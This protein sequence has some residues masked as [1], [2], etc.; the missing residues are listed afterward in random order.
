VATVAAEPETR[1]VKIP[2]AFDFL[3]EPH[4]YKVA[5]GGRGSGKS[6]SFAQLLLIEAIKRRIR[7]L[8]TR[9]IQKSI[10]DSVHQVLR[11]QIDR[12]GMESHFVVQETTIKSSTGSEFIFKGLQANTQ[13]IKSTERIN[14]CW[15]EEAESVTKDSWD[16][17]LPTILR[18]SDSELWV[19]FNTRHEDDDTY[20]RFVLNPPPGCVSRKV[21][22]SDNPWCPQ[23]LIEQ[24]EHMYAIDPD[25]A[26]HVWGGE[27]RNLSDAQ[28]LRGRYCVEAFEPQED[29]GGPYYGA[30][31][32]FAVDPTTLVRCWVHER[33]LYIE[34]EAY[35][36]GVDLDDTP[37]LF[38]SVP[39][40]RQHVIRADSARPETINHMVNHGFPRMAPAQKGPGSV[41]DGVEHLRS[42]KS[43]VIHPR[44]K[45][46]AQEA[47]L[48]SYKTDKYSGDVL[49]VLID[50]HNHCIDAIR[51]ALEPLI[52]S[53][54][55]VWV[56]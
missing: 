31:W 17:L 25:A 48:W 16:V 11:D 1:R 46:T 34:H 45:N 13:E 18:Q 50:K 51:Y 22:W 3:S 54:K 5:W 33:T 2:D 38:D 44:C 9:Q 14:Y 21:L 15:V 28:V 6:W 10:K 7:I 37:T 43:I 35:G 41:E 39:E 56:L 19:S 26:A 30:D 52:K 24:K 23:A 29:W 36:V 27:P 53:K 40:A 20:R 42:Y 12:L 4:R 47:R 55:S 49:P 8:C 32:G